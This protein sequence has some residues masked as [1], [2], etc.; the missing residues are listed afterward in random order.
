[1]LGF[2]DY[3]WRL[4]PG[5]PILLRVVETA[6]KR[7]RDMVV[8]CTYLGLLVGLVTFSMLQAQESGLDS[9]AKTSAQIFINMSF[10]QLAAV[11]LLAPVFTAGAITQEKDSQTYDILLATPLT[12][13]QI[14]LGSLGSR[15]F[16]VLMLL[17][18]G[19]P[20]FSITQIFGG[21]AIN[22]IVMSFLIAA[23]TATVTGALA[24][25]IATF[26]VGTRRTIFSFYLFIVIFLVGGVLLDR[27]PAFQIQG[28]RIN[29]S[30]EA[31]ISWFTGINPFLSQLVILHQ[32]Y[33]APPNILDLPPALQVW[34]I[35][36]YLSN[37][38]SF[39]V[40]SMFVL[41][42]VLI[43]PSV[44][45]LRVLAQSS[46]TIRGWVM[47]KLHLSTGSKNRKP[48]SVWSNPIA[49]REARTKASAAKASFVRYSFILAGLVGAIAMLFLFMSEK[50]YTTYITHGSYDESAR[51]LA[52]YR[53]SALET[54]SLTDGTVVM[55][56]G[57]QVNLN[58][59][60]GKFEVIAPPTIDAKKPR[61]INQIALADIPRRLVATEVRQYLLGAF[62][63]EFTVILLIVTN[64]AASTVTREKEDGTLDLLLTTPITSHYYIWG[65]L[66]GLVSYC[67]PLIAV[68]IAS[69]LIF[70]LY[71]LFRMLHEGSSFRWI[72]FP[73]A[74]LVMPAMFIIIVAF[75][76]ILGMNMSLRCRTTVR[77]VM[78]S[79]GI[80]VGICGALGF[81][82][83]QILDRGGS[84]I[85]LIFA[86][87][88]PF[89]ILT[90]LVDPY[91]YAVNVF[92]AGSTQ[93]GYGRFGILAAG[94]VAAGIYALI[95][96]SMYKAMVKNFDMTIRRQS[97]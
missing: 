62:F 54:Y 87:F 51:S 38:A 16:F 48:R 85:S 79:V 34:P 77:A 83:Y 95:V 6:G 63:I 73:E 12:N 97:R 36:W 90:L 76:A 33:Y 21:V 50:P 10:L 55:L 64:A 41:S 28:Q 27:V 72:I 11:A 74:V 65:K 94:W 84:Q 42:V 66:R 39:F 60:H 4:L 17:I 52:V 20:V 92:G 32:D 58:A 96:W 89:T 45:F 56:N 29:P 70:V 49:W 69:T 43:F 1:M 7:W 88:S 71:D 44:V 22:A 19:I 78:A 81:C 9:L 46:T 5:N 53:G 25:A 37:P 67:L 23:A 18:S 14:I 35:G 8:R 15:L 59:L 30:V 57:N 61:Q 3:F 24:M 68:P 86:S 26:K 93:I 82:G 75:A 47:Q 80:V 2:T 91:T 13:G 40:T 31:H